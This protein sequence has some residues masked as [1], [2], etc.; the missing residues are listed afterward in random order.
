MDVL[1]FGFPGGIA[2]SFIPSVA[3]ELEQVQSLEYPTINLFFF[4]DF[5][6]HG[7]NSLLTSG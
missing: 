2:L 5:C 4:F 1:S 6:L 3:P 7:L